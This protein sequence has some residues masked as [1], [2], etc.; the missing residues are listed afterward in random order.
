MYF[1]CLAK[2]DLKLFLRV[3]NSLSVHN[4][5]RQDNL[6]TMMDAPIDKICKNSRVRKVAAYHIILLSHKILLVLLNEIWLIITSENSLPESPLLR[7]Q[8]VHES[9]MGVS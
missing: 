2:G 3:G 4:L 8:N 6:L 7:Q 5:M 9:K 1:D